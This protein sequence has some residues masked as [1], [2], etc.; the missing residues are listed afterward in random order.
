MRLKTV[1]RGKQVAIGGDGQVSLGETTVKHDARKIRALAAAVAVSVLI[2]G[3]AL[4]RSAYLGKSRGE[5]QSLRAENTKLKE[6]NRAL[7]TL[8]D[9]IVL[10]REWRKEQLDWLAQL[11]HLSNTL[12]GAEA[13]YLDS[14]E[15]KPG[16]IK[17]LGRAKDRR[18]L[19]RFASD[20]MAMSGYEVRPGA[21]SS[22]RDPFG[23]DLKF[24]MDVSPK[25]KPILTTS[26]PVRRPADDGALQ[27]PDRRPS[28]YTR[29][30]SRIRR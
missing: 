17:L 13:L 30:R 4:A 11:A 1:R 8:R 19:S 3:A 21:T 23:Y 5:A 26:R 16:T 6:T 29:P 18:S 20:L 27:A 9:R 10:I 2:G 25:A 12:P 22:V 28:R 15:C 7:K 14:V 24:D